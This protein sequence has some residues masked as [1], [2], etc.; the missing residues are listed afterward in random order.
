MK[1]ILKFA[2]ILTIAICCQPAHAEWMR[3]TTNSFA[4]FRDVYFFDHKNGWIIGSDG[5]MLSTEDGGSTWTQTKKFTTDAFVQIY[6][7]DETNGWLLCERNIYARGANPTS[8]LR[9]T[10]DGG[11]TWE[12]VEFQDGGRERVTRMLFHE[13]GR[14]TAFGE[15][16]IFFGLQEDRASWKKSRTAIHY[17]L[18]DGAFANEKVGA[19]VGTGGTILFTEDAGFTWEKAT[20]LGDL[21]T[22]FN[23]V[24]FAAKG[25]WAV[26]S[27][28]RIFRSTGARL[29]RQVSSGVTADLNDVYFTSAT[30]G[31]AVGND[32][33]IIRTRDGG[34]TWYAVNSR[35]THKLERIVFA[36]GRGWAVGFGGTV[37]TY[38]DK[39]AGT[40]QGPRPI[41]MRKG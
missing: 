34:T 33:V 16:G 32:G 2:I 21:S 26:G 1:I 19:I 22:R 37:L 7:E 40:D 15:G 20:L 4:W 28:G 17:L 10:T 25:G 27:N 30:S 13:D 8:Y 6:F 3:Q 36:N 31:W 35:T 38:D 9:R 5:V 18:T 11:R 12:K 41:L 14:A 24:D 23:A 29:W 39:P